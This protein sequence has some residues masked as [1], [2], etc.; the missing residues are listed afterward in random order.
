MRTIFN[1][2]TNTTGEFVFKGTTSSKYN[3]SRRDR[4]LR[5]VLLDVGEGN[6]DLAKSLIVHDLSFIATE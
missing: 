3:V 5:R 2:R 6:S 1:S 4:F